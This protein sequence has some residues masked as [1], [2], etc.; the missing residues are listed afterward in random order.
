MSSWLLSAFAD[1]ASPMVD[2]QIQALKAAGIRWIDPR[3]VDG[4]N[5][6][7]LPVDHARE[8]AAKFKAA[9]IAVGMFGSPIGKIDITEDFAIDQAKL[10]QLG[11]LQPIFNCMGVR[12]FSYYNRENASVADWQ[13]ESL[14]RLGALTEQAQKLGLVLYHENE[15]HIFGDRCEQICVLRDQ[16]RSTH[17]DHFKL[18]FDFDNFNQSGDNVWDNWLALRDASDA[19]HLKDSRRL[20]DGSCQHVPVGLGDGQIPRI[21]ADAAER[22]WE[23]PLTLEPH[24][25][26]SAAVV[27][28]GPSGSENASL[29][30]LTPVQTFAI[31]AEHARQLIEQVGRL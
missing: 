3:Q 10:E 23:G 2:D 7:E 29:R 13:A 15:R 31:A 4:I 18:I 14:R 26:R 24:L 16:L 17:G 20:P 22:G 21:L 25:S 19:I 5:I 30:D 9:G 28:T 12:M 27:A 8:V 11:R 1:E 6:T